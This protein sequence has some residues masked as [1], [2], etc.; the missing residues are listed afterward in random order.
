MP[1]SPDKKED[2]EKEDEEED[3]KWQGCLA[4]PTSVTGIQCL[5]A[6]IKDERFAKV[7]LCIGAL[8][9]AFLYFGRLNSTLGGS[10]I[11]IG[12]ALQCFLSFHI[13]ILP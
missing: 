12:R 2:E 8:W 13:V 11:D 10:R 1:Y 6:G 9:V 7:F 3:R 4:V 5:P